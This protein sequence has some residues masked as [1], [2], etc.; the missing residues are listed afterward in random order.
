MQNISP[1]YIYFIYVLL[2]TASKTDLSELILFMNLLII[3][4]NL[5]IKNIYVY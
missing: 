4:M 5:G 3:K 2:E 1:V